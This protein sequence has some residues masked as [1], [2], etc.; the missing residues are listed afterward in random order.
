MKIDVAI[1][2]YKK[3]ES[4]IYTLMSLKQI[5]GD[6]I[7]TVYIN[8]DCSGKEVCD[9]YRS[10][11]VREYFKPWKLDVRENTHSIGI[12]QAYIRGYY[13][14]YMGWKFFCKRWWR[15][16]SPKYGHN[17]FDIRYQYA[18]EHT[19]KKYMLILHDDIKF[20]KNV[21]QVY[22]TA[23]EQNPELTIV[24][25]L[26]QCWLCHFS[27]FCNKQELAKG[28]FPSKY[29]PQTPSKEIKNPEEFDPKKGFTYPCRI[30][31]WC[32]MVNV[33]KANE[34][35]QKTRTFFGNMYP[36]ADTAA[37]WFAEGIRYG[38]KFGDLLS[39]EYK[40]YYNHGWQGFSGHSVWVN[41]GKGQSVY[42]AN[43]IISQIEKDFGFKW[44]QIKG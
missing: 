16:F 25:Q 36:H 23:L 31:E 15:F 8:D 18:L 43:M 27:K 30:N 22:V 32:C 35:T 40:E 7:D 1:N 26:G 20:M 14:A 39:N 10:E 37:Y 5:A 17:R 3:P 41:Q 21:V 13:P 29:W 34:I 6:M 38:L 44:S 4:L 2:S 19:D 12:K 42:D 33:Q 9:I 28:R 24:G 11:A